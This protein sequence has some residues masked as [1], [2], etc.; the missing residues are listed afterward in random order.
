MPTMLPET[1]TCTGGD[2]VYADPVWTI[3][4]E[5]RKYQ[6]ELNDDERHSAKWTKSMQADTE[7]YFWQLYIERSGPQV[8]LRWSQEEMAPM[9]ACIPTVMM[10]DD[11]DIFDGW[12][13]YNVERHNSPV[14]QVRP[15]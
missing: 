4:E 1:E 2:Q 3:T 13:S 15:F 10:W 14:Y 12:G 11:H 5:W 7:D 8:T 9:F 6:F